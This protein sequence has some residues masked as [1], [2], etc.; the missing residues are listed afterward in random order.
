MGSMG[1]MGVLEAS[2]RC[3]KNKR[4]MSSDEARWIVVYT[5]ASAFLYIISDPLGLIFESTTRLIYIHP[6]CSKLAFFILF[7][8]LAMYV[9]LYFSELNF[10]SGYRASIAYEWDGQNTSF[11]RLAPNR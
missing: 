11:C 8:S 3:C 4:Q 2:N 9:F 1:D 10:I 5:L 6:W 7:V